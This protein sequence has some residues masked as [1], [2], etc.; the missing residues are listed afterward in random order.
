MKGEKMDEAIA[1][2]EAE[3]AEYNR[4]M[5]ERITRKKEERKR[6]IVARDWKHLERVHVDPLEFMK[7]LEMASRDQI[8]KAMSELKP[9]E[10]KEEI[11]KNETVTT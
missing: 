11:T 6:D 3:R 8:Q 7:L 2:L 4:M 9:G 10:D 5:D 1:K